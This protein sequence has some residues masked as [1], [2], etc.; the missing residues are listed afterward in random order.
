MARSFVVDLG[1]G[2]V[3]GLAVGAAGAALLARVPLTTPGLY[4]VASMALGPIALGIGDALHGSGFL[5]IDLAGLV[6]GGAP[7]ARLEAMA[8]F[9]DGL[10]WVAQLVMFLVLGLLVFPGDLGPV[11][12]QGTVLAA[13]RR[14]RRPAS[15]DDR[16]HDR[17]GV[18][19]A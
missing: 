12:V 6:L 19:S 13:H 7:L 3:A 2:A 5:S 10:A 4:P 1:A 18:R 16:G 15:G 14:R 8:T 11:A 9:H 17:G